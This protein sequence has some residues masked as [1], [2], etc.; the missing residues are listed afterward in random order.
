MV[1]MYIKY[2]SPSRLFVLGLSLMPANAIAQPIITAKSPAANAQAP[3]T[4]AIT[5]AFSQPLT[6]SSSAALRVYS[7]QRGGLRTRETTPAVVSGN[8]LAF[9]P[10]AYPFMPG[11]TVFSTTTRA[12]SSSS[13]NLIRPVVMQFT[14]ATGGLGR[15]AFQIGSNPV[16]GSNPEGLVLGDVDGD[17]DLDMLTTNPS[18]NT[19]SIRLNGSDATGS[20]TGSFGVLQVVSVGNA[21]VHAALGDVDSDG[22]LDLLTANFG[23]A[24]VSVRMNNG[25]GSFNGS[26]DV[27]VG[28][29]PSGTALGDIDGD[30]DL[31]LVTANQLSGSASVRLNNG[32]GVFSG[33]QDVALGS[34][35]TSV[36]LGDVDNDGDLDMLSV[37]FNSGTMSVRLNGGNAT[38]PNSGLFSGGSD[39]AVG[40]TP[41]GMALGD[42]DG[43]GDLDVVAAISGGAR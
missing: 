40:L 41:Y 8:V 17:G 29:S 1:N 7:A 3:R 25:A 38:G 14:A 39:V 11:E 12:A 30:G 9:T 16:I 6:A 19:V 24:T 43:D 32:A 10:N 4:S 18:D 37:N 31:D 28:S 5:I 26:Q 15:E 35:P 2:T 34:G 23:G 20:N 13:G 21:P 22:D 42:V 33:A 27:S 36:A